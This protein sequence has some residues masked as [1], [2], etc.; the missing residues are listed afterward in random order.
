VTTTSGVIIFRMAMV[1][2]TMRRLLF[3]VLAAALLPACAWAQAGSVPNI[4]AASDLQFAL[5]DIARA[6][7]N[8]T[9]LDVKLA[10]GSSGNLR[11][12]IAEGAPFELFLSADEAYV[13]A[14]AREGRT[15]DAGVRYAIGRLVLFVPAGSP[16]EPDATLADLRAA[17]A[18][19]RVKRFAI[20]NPEHAPYGRAAREALQ[21]AG[22]W[23]ALAPRLVLGENVAQAAQ[24]ASTG[25][26]Q[27]GIF[28]HSLALAPAIA[29]RG[30]AVLL[31]ANMHAPLAQ[32]MV[33]VKGAGLVAHAFARY[34][35]QPAAREIL[36]RHGF[37]LPDA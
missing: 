4:A 14:L 8:D 30:Q 23:D 22:L 9:S 34:L 35:Q 3:A 18:D 27:G 6:F 26:A 29:A 19:G 2:R 33:L 15:V 10:F 36:R 11:R 1:T 25:A 17:L 13:D 20:A 28:A 12:Q 7:R 24:F 21:R 32:R 5:S 37:E 31:P 16:L